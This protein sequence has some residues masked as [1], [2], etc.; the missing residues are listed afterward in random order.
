MRLRIV[1]VLRDLIYCLIKNLNIV[2]TM[3]ISKEPT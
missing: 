1:D 2:D 3:Q